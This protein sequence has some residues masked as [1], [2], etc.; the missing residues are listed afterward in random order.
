MHLYE[1]FKPKSSMLLL[2][3]PD[4]LFE[5]LKRVYLQ[6]YVWLNALKAGFIEHIVF[7]MENERK[8]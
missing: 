5:K 4:S 2:P 7:R 1:T 3:D 6:C 8:L